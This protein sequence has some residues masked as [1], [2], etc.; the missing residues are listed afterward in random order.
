VGVRNGSRCSIFAWIIDCNFHWDTEAYT[1]QRKECPV[2]LDPC[3]PKAHR[4]R[5]GSS[6]RLRRRRPQV[7]SLQHTEKQEFCRLRR[8]LTLNPRQPQCAF[9]AHG[10][11]M[12]GHWDHESVFERDGIRPQHDTQL[13]PFRFASHTPARLPQGGGAGSWPLGPMR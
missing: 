7:L 2:I 3:A 8:R 5:R 4:G 10:S 12:T 1:A 6:V 13:A 9:G 11:R